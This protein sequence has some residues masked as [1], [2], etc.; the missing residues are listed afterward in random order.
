MLKD[1]SYKEK[2]KFLQL[3]WSWN[4]MQK[5]LYWSEAGSF[6]Q[7][8]PSWPFPVAPKF[9]ASWTV[10]LSIPGDNHLIS[11]SDFR[12]AGSTLGKDS[13]SLL[14]SQEPSSFPNQLKR[15][16]RRA[17]VRSREK[18][19][20]VT[21]VPGAGYS[22][23][24]GSGN[25]VLMIPKCSSSPQSVLWPLNLRALSE[26]L[27]SSAHVVL[28]LSCPCLYTDSED[29]GRKIKPSLSPARKWQ[30]F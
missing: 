9:S 28:P 2:K 19:T 13:F 6:R 27:L 16:N 15:K 30:T 3:E 8:S 25:P 5:Q 10:T 23:P 11:T 17:P 21:R 24:Q 4:E 1:N 26:S 14:T 18:K 20:D 29:N 7:S 12:T 22:A